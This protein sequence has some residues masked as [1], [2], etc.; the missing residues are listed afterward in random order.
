MRAAPRRAEEVCA[1]PQN[2]AQQQGKSRHID[3][4]VARIKSNIQYLKAWTAAIAKGRQTNDKS[5]RVSVD[6]VFKNIILRTEDAS[7][8]L[9]HRLAMSMKITHKSK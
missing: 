9:R 6:E 7:Q 2:E 3:D 5:T 8:G 1:Q 4:V